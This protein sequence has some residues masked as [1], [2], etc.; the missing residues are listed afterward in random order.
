MAKQNFDAGLSQ[1]VSCLGVYLTAQCASAY[2]AYTC[3]NT[4]NQCEALNA[5]HINVRRPCRSLCTDYCDACFVAS[6]PC[7]DLPTGEG[8]FTVEAAGLLEPAVPDAAAGVTPRAAMAAVVVGAT[9]VSVAWAF[10][11]IAGA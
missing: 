5:T 10:A 1:V 8:C 7:Y 11:D 9:A 4:F 3:A 2:M 6:C